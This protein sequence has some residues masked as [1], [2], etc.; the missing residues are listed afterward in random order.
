MGSGL[1]QLRFSDLPPAEWFWLVG[2]ARNVRGGDL[3]RD[4]RRRRARGIRRSDGDG[5]ERVRGQRHAVASHGIRRVCARGLRR[6]PG[7]HAK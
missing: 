3:T 1:G 5:T 6:G 4:A 7:S 2:V